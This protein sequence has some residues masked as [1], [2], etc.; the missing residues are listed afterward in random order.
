[1]STSFEVESGLGESSAS[2]DKERGTEWVWADKAG[3]W[4]SR[5]AAGRIEALKSSTWWAFLVVALAI[6]CVAYA[7]NRAEDVS[8]GYLYILP[9]SFSAIL[10]SARLTY[11]MVVVCIFFHDLFGSPIHHIQGRILHN[12]AALVGFTFVV[13]ILQWFVAQRNA[14]H[15]MTRQ[16]RDALLQEVELAAEVQ[17]LFLPRSDPETAGFE[18]AGAMHPARVVGGDY[19]DYLARPDGRMRLVIADVSGKGV[20]AALLMSATAAAVQLETNEPRKLSD[21]AGHLN[22]E[23]YALQDDG[24]FVTVLLG[25]LDPRNGQLK[26]INCGHNPALLLRGDGGEPVWLHAS[27]TPVGMMPEMDCKLEEITLAPGDLMVWYTD[28]VTEAS[29][30]KAEE[31]GTDRLLESVRAHRGENARG[32]CEQLWRDVA[33]FTGKESLDDDLT[34]IVVK[35]KAVLEPNEFPPFGD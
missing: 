15:E 9:L 26:Y 1:M 35:M 18:L 27:C 12:L 22:R 14:L 6:G 11:G 8:L 16:Q 21:V 28:G 19:Y 7:D 34:L 31:F 10:L 25:E 13:L 24:R 3:R 29:N 4:I 23:L 20:A 30:Q 33:A 5:V 32:I 2:L 17:R